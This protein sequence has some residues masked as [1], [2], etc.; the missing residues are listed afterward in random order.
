M[1]SGSSKFIRGMTAVELLI[2]VAIAATL[3]LFTA[4][5][6]AAMAHKA[7]SSLAGVNLVDSLTRARSLAIVRESDVVLCPSS[8]G[9]NCLKSDHW[10]SG[11]IAFGDLHEDGERH[12][13]EPVLLHQE[14]LGAK[15]HL[16]STE[17]RTRLRFQPTGSNGGSNVTFTLCDGRGPK[18]AVAWILS[19]KGDLRSA[20][21]SGAAA[22]ACAG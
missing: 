7:R 16:V 12:A 4:N 2:V 13:N 15:V 9:S 20:P 8:D 6:I 19:N 5:A 21:A 1:Q 22:E 3:G 11:W 14:A 18:F 17:G 10:E